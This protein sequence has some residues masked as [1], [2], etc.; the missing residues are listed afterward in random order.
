MLANIEVIV[1]DDGSKDKTLSICQEYAETNS[2]IKI[3]SKE[4]GGQSSARNL[5]NQICCWR[6]SDVC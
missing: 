1:V 3:I 5:G 4:N 6:I 2:C